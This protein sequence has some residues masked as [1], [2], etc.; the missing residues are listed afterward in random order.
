MV[1]SQSRS[2]FLSA[3]FWLTRIKGMSFFP[4]LVLFKCL[5]RHYISYLEYV[6]AIKFNSS[7]M[8]GL[9]VVHQDPVFSHCRFPSFICYT[10]PS[11]ESQPAS[12]ATLTPNFS[13]QRCWGCNLRKEWLWL[14]PVSTSCGVSQ[15]LRR[16]GW[17][18]PRWE[19][20]ASY[21]KIWFPSSCFRY[22]PFRPNEGMRVKY[23]AQSLIS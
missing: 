4:K 3:S 5:P 8:E 15:D 17:V 18:A 16:S 12:W 20:W 23:L 22:V 14:W 13:L 10:C 11:L 6:T 2:Y 21:K 7:I 9:H 19:E 1:L